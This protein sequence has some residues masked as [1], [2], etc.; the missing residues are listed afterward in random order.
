MPNTYSAMSQLDSKQYPVNLSER[1]FARLALLRSGTH[2]SS[3][4]IST[5]MLQESKASWTRL[6]WYCERPSR[7]STSR[8]SDAT[9]R[10]KQL[11][12]LTTVRKSDGTR[13]TGLCGT[14]ISSLVQDRPAIKRACNCTKIARSSRLVSNR[15]PDSCQWSA[16]LIRGGLDH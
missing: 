12:F 1:C 2:M 10:R 8:N 9:I 14:A 5:R 7:L 3:S 11:D 6:S 16:A 13:S 4:V 15:S